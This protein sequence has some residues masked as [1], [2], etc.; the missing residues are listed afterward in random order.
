MLDWLQL[1]FMQRALF[2]GL[3]VAAIC[4]MIGLFLVLRRLSLIGDGL[5]HIAFSGV[6]AGFLLQIYPVITALVFTVLGAA[7][8][9]WLR[10][11]QRAYGDLILAIFFYSG[12]AGGVVL[13][14]LGDSLS[15]AQLFGYLFGSISTI[16]ESDVW[17]I[18]GLGIVV[19]AI[20]ILFYKELFALS[21]DEA[22]ARVSGI[23]VGTLNM[24]VAVTTAVTVSL[25][26]RVVGLLMV[27][28]LMVIPVATALQLGRGFRAT[29]A[30]SVLFSMVSLTTGLAASYYLDLPPGGTIVLAA[31]GLFLATLALKVVTQ[32]V[33]R[34]QA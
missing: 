27:A 14:K 21:F 12:I 10:S 17:F 4:P 20:I 23:R 24:L 6:A 15:T 19:A 3:L 34:V 8:I 2:A 18:L 30:F 9:E 11:R 25:G 32:Q 13:S 5:G 26:M 22:T 33:R 1:E 31:V 16:G 29:L 28:A 7:G